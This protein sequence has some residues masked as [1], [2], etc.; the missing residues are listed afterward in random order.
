MAEPDDPR[1]LSMQVVRESSISRVE[2]QL[3]AKVYDLLV[4]A[5]QES[6]CSTPNPTERVRNQRL[7]DSTSHKGFQL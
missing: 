4:P 1:T 7:S 5:V 2:R 6:C 3:L